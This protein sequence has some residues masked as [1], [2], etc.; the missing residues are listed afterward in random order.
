MRYLYIEKTEVPI[1]YQY[2]DIGDI[3]TIFSI[4]IEPTLLHKASDSK[5]HMES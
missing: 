4:Y 3:S 2:I 5:L 1:Q